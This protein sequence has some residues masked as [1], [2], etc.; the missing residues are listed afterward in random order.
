MKFNIL[1][2]E[3]EYN[4]F[5]EKDISS[6]IFTHTDLLK[7]LNKYKN[8]CKIDLLGYSVEKRE[9]FQLSYGYGNIKVLI[10]SQMHGNET[11]GTLSIFD[12]LKFFK[13]KSLL[14][15]FL[16]N[17]LNFIFI[18]MLNPDGAEKFQRR[19]A[20]NIDLN[21]DAKSL[22]SPEIKLLFNKVRKFQPDVLFNLH[23]QRSIF[24][25]GETEQPAILSFLSP[26]EDKQKTITYNRKKTMGIIAFIKNKLSELIPG[27][28]GRYSDEFYPTATGDCFQQLGYSCILF[29]SGY[30]LKDLDKQQSRK[31]NT[32]ALLAGFYALTKNKDIIN[33]YTFYF[34][35]P[36]NG[37]KLLD[38]IYKQ[39]KIQKNFIEIIV[40]IGLII[41]EN[42]DINNKKLNFVY[43]IID[44]GDLNQF[45]SREKI[46]ANGKS[47]IGENGRTYPKIGDIS[48]FYLK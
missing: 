23:D 1:S 6:R 31:Y 21:R 41:E 18:P 14:A 38:K 42:Y 15:N 8:L 37:Q 4:I 33:Y 2:L 27:N 22:Q 16:T 40:D 10:W 9:I 24:H 3:K 47:Y 35:I 5:K 7:Q 11:T 45:F 36:E 46:E 19:N 30:C 29:E 12:I 28:I 26:S 13:K 43:K 34:S 17:Y 39:V 32:L 20:L 44:I 25:V 48:K